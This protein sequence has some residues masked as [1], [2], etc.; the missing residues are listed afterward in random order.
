MNFRDNSTFIEH[1]KTKHKYSLYLCAVC[2]E[3]FHTPK[4]LKVH[5]RMR[6]NEVAFDENKVLPTCFNN[7]VNYNSGEMTNHG[8]TNYDSNSSF[9]LRNTGEND[10]EE[11]EAAVAALQS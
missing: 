1:R 4:A 11:M 7:P 9:M 3:A 10:E 2:S 8:L 6:H 5:M